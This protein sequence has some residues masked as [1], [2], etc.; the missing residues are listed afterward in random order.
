MITI[1][2]TSMATIHAI[3]FQSN[4]ESVCINVTLCDVNYFCSVGR[5]AN[6]DLRCEAGGL[7][8]APRNFLCKPPRGWR[9]HQSHSAAAK[10]GPGH[11]GTETVRIPQVSIVSNSSRSF[12]RSR[13]WNTHECR[14]A[15]VL[16]SSHGTGPILSSVFGTYQLCP[17]HVASASSNCHTIQYR[18]HRR[19]I[20]I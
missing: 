5:C 13:P 10:A 8:V 6:V 18:E 1:T 7:L 12:N 19:H 16:G 17:C 20:P 3:L 9:S 15:P 14:P 11:L 4:F 2:P